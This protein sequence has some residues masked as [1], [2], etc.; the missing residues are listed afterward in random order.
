MCLDR[1]KSIK[2]ANNCKGKCISFIAILI[3]LLFTK[4]TKL[5]QLIM[6]NKFRTSARLNNFITIVIFHLLNA[7]GK[8]KNK[9]TN[10][11]FVSR[12][13]L[14]MMCANYK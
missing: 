3:T 2:Q 1:E 11:L 14:A 6:K 7:T 12:G 10:L 13:K 4:N 9:L 8:V 5:K